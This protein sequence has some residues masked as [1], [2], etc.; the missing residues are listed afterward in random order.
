MPNFLRVTVG[1]E[2]ENQRFVAALESVLN[3]AANS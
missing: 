1:T 3:P 2:T